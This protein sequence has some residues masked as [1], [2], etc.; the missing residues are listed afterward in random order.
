MDPGSSQGNCQEEH[1]RFHIRAY[2]QTQ[3]ELAQV[4][5]ETVSE[6]CADL[7]GAGSIARGQMRLSYVLSH[8]S[9]E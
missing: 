4:A 5:G 9:T 7:E 2:Y 8:V 1:P 3:G 6:G